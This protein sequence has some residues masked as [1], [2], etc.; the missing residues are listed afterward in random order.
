VFDLPYFADLHVHSTASDGELTPEEAVERAAQA[1]V[2]AVAL[3]DHDTLAGV[4]RAAARASMLGLE[5]VPGCELT[6]YLGE[7]ELHLL[8]LFVDL[9]PGSRLS[10]R[11][12]ELRT[13]RRARAMEMGARLRAAKF[14]VSD[15]EILSAAGDA[16]SLGRPHVAEALRRA[17]H[18]PDVRTAYAR[19]LTPGGAGYVPKVDFAPSEAIQVIHSAGGLALLAHPGLAPRDEAL[20]S[21]WEMGLDGLETRHPA[22]SRENTRRYERLARARG[23]AISGGSDYHGPHL[24]P[25][26]SIGAAGLT[27]ELLEDL[28]QRAKSRAAEKAE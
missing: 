9:D 6:A 7:L 14:A 5:V 4:A 20:P 18:A 24:T 28:R 23:K 10:R 11:L 13:A 19:F 1:G 22:H 15:A 25:K 2:R 12:A 26:L 8:A 3:A 16:Q 21:L 27:E 17:G